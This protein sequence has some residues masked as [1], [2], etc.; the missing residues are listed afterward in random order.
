MREV[1]V[2]VW[3]FAVPRYVYTHICRRMCI[4]IFR[5]YR[6]LKRGRGRDTETER[7]RE[8]E[9]ERLV[10]YTPKGPT[11]QIIGFQ[12]PSSMKF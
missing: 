2:G 10:V 1:A 3:G 8:R 12:G 4:H 5:K 6:N 11:T 7:E 9:R